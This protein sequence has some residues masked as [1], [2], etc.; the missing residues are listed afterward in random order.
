[1]RNLWTPWRYQYI[2]SQ[3]SNGCVFCDALSSAD[4]E[5]AL[6]LHR[7]R[8]N[9]VLLN[10]YPYSNGHLMIAPNEH[11]STPVETGNDTINDMAVLMKEAVQVLNEAYNPD[12]F[13]IG[14]NIGTAAG[15]GIKDHFHLH[16]VPRWHG[17]TNYMTSIGNTRLIPQTLE[18]I[19]KELKYLFDKLHKNDK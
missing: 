4:E 9:F 17:D 6:V 2:R 7:G 14:M 13:N 15:A 16:V 18:E 8:L 1:M 10:R 12:G 19:W 3:K 11:I 5:Q